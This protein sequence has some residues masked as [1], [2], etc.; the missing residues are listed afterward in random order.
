[1]LRC[2]C[3]KSAK[4]AGLGGKT[5][6]LQLLDKSHAFA[7]APPLQNSRKLAPEWYLKRVWGGRHMLLYP[8]PGA[9]VAVVASYGD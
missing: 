8:Y 4:L 7:R 6:A 2:L 3:A 5:Y 9:K 1:M